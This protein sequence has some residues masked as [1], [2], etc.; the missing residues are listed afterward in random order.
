MK[1]IR[2]LMFVLT[3]GTLVL[4]ACGGA[5][6]PTVG[7]GK[8]EAMPVAFIGT[9]D[10]MAGDQWVISGTTVTV[11]PA[12]VRDGPFNVGDKV[13]VEGLVNADGSFTVSRVEV[14]APQDVS[15]L[16]P[17]GDDN[18]NAANVNDDN[19]NI[20]ASDINDDHGSDANLND[21]HG[22][23][24]NLNDDN[25][26]AVNSDD[27]NINDDNSNAGNTNDDNSNTASATSNTNDDHSDSGKSGKGGGGN[28]NGG[29]GKGGGKDS[30]GNSNDG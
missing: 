28:D 26:N 11:D 17:F 7:S 12:V 16:P 19:A 30:G 25:G 24:A 29:S 5:A 3:I 8:V 27:T 4:S 1:N 23:D 18:S 10:S 20:N 2:F 15:A 14:P 9:V 6:A 21:D 13:K 22:S